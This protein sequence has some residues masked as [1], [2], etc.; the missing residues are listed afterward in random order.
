MALV[1]PLN[2]ISITSVTMLDF[3]NNITTPVPNIHHVWITDSD[4]TTLT[5]LKTLLFYL[6]KS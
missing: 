5:H 3:I 4:K 6:A 2:I 1:D